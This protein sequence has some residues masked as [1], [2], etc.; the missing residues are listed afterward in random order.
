VT[1]IVA[2]KLPDDVYRE[3]ERK[4]RRLG[5]SLVSDYVRDVIMREL[6]YKG[7]PAATLADVERVVERKLREQGLQVDLDKI[8][9]RLERK[10]Q[11][12][13]NPWTAKIDQVSARL[14]EVVERLDAL[15]E[16]VKGL[17]EEVKSLREHATRPST[18]ERREAR[19]VRRRSAIE[20]LREQGVVF[21]HDVQ[22]LRD[23]DA[24]FERLRREGAIIL[25][26]GGERVAVDPTFWENFKDKIEKLP[27]ANDEEIKVLLRDTEYQLFRKLKESGLIYFDAGKRAWRFVETARQS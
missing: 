20:R 8:L 18:V 17:E 2:L 13:I 14:A 27:T 7:E 5:Y 6:G 23:R 10:I 19:P 1:R 4:A 3:L 24:F 26:V 21:E 25:D 11:D 9:A 16:K 15:E 12:M 22:W